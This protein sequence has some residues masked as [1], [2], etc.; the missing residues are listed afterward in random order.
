[1][2]V[3]V[4]LAAFVATAIASGKHF[5]AIQRDL[6]KGWRERLYRFLSEDE[7]AAMVTE[8]IARA[9]RAFRNAAIGSAVVAALMLAAVLAITAR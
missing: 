9:E 8:P 4:A 5:L 2:A 1:M 7:Y 3:T 6:R